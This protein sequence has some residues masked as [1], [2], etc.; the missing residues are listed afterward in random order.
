[1]QKKNKPNAASIIVFLVMYC[2]LLFALNNKP[3]FLV[4]A[5]A[6][7]TGP[8]LWDVLFERF[9]PLV[10]QP[11]Y[12]LSDC[13]RWVRISQVRRYIRLSRLNFGHFYPDRIKASWSPK[14]A[15]IIDELILSS[16][17]FLAERATEMR[18]LREV[19]I[20]N[21]VLAEDFPEG[22][23]EVF[24]NFIRYS[25]PSEIIDARLGLS[26][27]VSYEDFL[28]AVSMSLAIQDNYRSY[29]SILFVEKILEPI[30]RDLK[31]KEFRGY[32]FPVEDLPVFFRRHA[33][34]VQYVLDNSALMVG[35]SVPNPNEICMAR[36]YAQTFWSIYRGRP[37]GAYSSMINCFKGLPPIHEPGLEFDRPHYFHSD[38]DR[39][40]WFL[41]LQAELRY[42][43]YC[44]FA[45]QIL[46]MEL[47]HYRELIIWQLQKRAYL[48]QR[49]YEIRD[50]IS[51]S[52]LKSLLIQELADLRRNDILNL[53]F[54]KALDALQTIDDKVLGNSQSN[55][56]KGAIIL[57]WI[58]RQAIDRRMGRVSPSRGPIL[59]LEEEEQRVARESMEK[60]NTIG[61]GTKK[62]IE[63]YNWILCYIRALAV[64]NE[65]FYI[66]RSLKEM[67]QLHSVLV[68]N[69]R[70]S[71]T[72][73]DRRFIQL[74]R[75]QLSDE[76][77]RF[78][79]LRYYIITN[80]FWSHQ[81]RRQS[82]DMTVGEIILP[83]VKIRDEWFEIQ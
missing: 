10:P 31:A 7:F 74:R 78:D 76:Q 82:G 40:K 67:T 28:S 9:P 25:A 65:R 18:T 22:K 66:E 77:R 15:E 29:R 45:N 42:F 52:F 17:Q 23:I 80:H 64:I 49:F 62:E 39:H 46:E 30:S 36:H 33:A 48:A 2:I 6:S 57:P 69:R 54:K 24:K 53:N 56:F 35:V 43:G 44:V 34:D 1:M 11:F 61:S 3:K 21:Y 27:K 70:V 8:T 16:K 58:N 32:R 68:S 50:N 19:K 63:K 12:S 47:E 83:W 73:L 79:D 75:H 38:K 20:N 59:F 26:S 51:L 41:F 71:F 81:F 37:F 14:D 60:E 4:S 5:E 72:E 55:A 13:E